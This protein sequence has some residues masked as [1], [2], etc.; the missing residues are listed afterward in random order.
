MSDAVRRYAIRRVNPFLGVFQIVETAGGRAVSANG[1]VWEIELIAELASGWGSLNQHHSDTAYYRYGLWSRE[2]GLINRPLA[3]HLR[4]QPLRSQCDEVL[5]ALADAVDAL[6]FALADNRELW[7]FD[8]WN[9]RPLALLAT[10]AEGALAPMPEPRYWSAALGRHGTPG[11][12]RFPAAQAVEELIKKRAGF[13]I[14]KHWIVR[15][16]EGAG[17]IE[18]TGESL[19]ASAFPVFLLT[20]D[21]DDPADAALIA[22]YLAWI[23]P[24]LLTLQ[25]LTP[26]QRLAKE[27]QVRLQAVSIEHH[28]HLYPSVINEQLLLAARVQCRLQKQ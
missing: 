25:H 24:A 2:E 9:K 8:D 19:P 20:E 17:V 1:V 7:L 15:D 3:P 5:A 22:D 23:A 18:V 13:N 16:V 12:L 10:L 27:Q 26:E 21:W 14:H 28:C 4:E 6:P 11:Q